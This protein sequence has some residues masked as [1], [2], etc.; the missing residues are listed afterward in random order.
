MSGRIVVAEAL[1]D[2]LA[3][4]TTDYGGCVTPSWSN[5]KLWRK[6]QWSVVRALATHSRMVRAERWIGTWSILNRL[7][8]FRQ[9]SG[10]S[11]FSDGRAMEC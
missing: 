10:I 11:L 2:D 9:H 5:D 1:C 6:R 8:V 4:G 7:T 3:G